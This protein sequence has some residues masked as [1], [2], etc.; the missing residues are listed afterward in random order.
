M[1]SAGSRGG[2]GPFASTLSERFEA[3]LDTS[4]MRYL[5]EWRLYLASVALATTDK[6][7]AAVAY[8]AGYGTEAAFNRAF[9]RAYGIPP[10][11]WRQNARYGEANGGKRR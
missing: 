4:P 5:R 2:R 1:V 10:A 11:A 3:V 6:A 9:S 8:E 7:I